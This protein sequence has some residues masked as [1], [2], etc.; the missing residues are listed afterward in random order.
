M[1]AEPLKSATPD[2]ERLEP[3]IVAIT[4][5]LSLEAENM[6]VSK[7][8]SDALNVYKRVSSSSIV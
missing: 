5:S 1:T 2:T 4:L 6:S 3:S 7:S 8:T